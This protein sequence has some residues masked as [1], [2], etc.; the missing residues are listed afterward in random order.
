MCCGHQL[1]G[2]LPLSL[3]RFPEGGSWM[4][5]SGET[6]GNWRAVALFTCGGALGPLLI[7]L[8][9]ALG[10]LYPRIGL[11][12][13]LHGFNL[14]LCP[15]QCFGVI[16]YSIGFTRTAVL[17]GS[18]NLLL[19]WWF[20]LVLYRLVRGLAAWIVTLPLAA[21]V[22]VVWVFFGMNETL[23]LNGFA[24]L[25]AAGLFYYG[26]FKLGRSLIR[27]PRNGALSMGAGAR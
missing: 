17:L 27:P 5:V 19:F 8:V 20:A 10:H 2:A 13:F 23:D 22:V 26:L 3:R 15:A 18:A 24:V 11:N 16:E 25:V 21:G 7:E 12:L 6:E 9:L 4:R 1:P 14:F